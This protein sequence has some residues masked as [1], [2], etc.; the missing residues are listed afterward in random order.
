MISF[1]WTLL[2]S[3]SLNIWKKS[4]DKTM[5]QTEEICKIQGDVK[6]LQ[7]VEEF[8]LSVEITIKIVIITTVK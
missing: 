8:F 3:G 4:D 7:R 5:A 1:R 2:K 6:G